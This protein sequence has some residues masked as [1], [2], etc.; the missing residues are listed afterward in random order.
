MHIPDGSL[1]PQT[2]LA[3]FA[4]AAPTIAV[5]SRR[6]TT[7]VKTRNVPMLAM[8]AAVSFLVMM[9]NIP[10]PDGTS[11]H[12]VGAVIIAIALGPWA[13]VIAVSVALLFQAL[14]FG[15][16]GLLAYG[17]NVLNLA[18][19]M[20][21]SGLAVYRLLA[22]RSPLTSRRR[23][24]AAG[25]GGF[26]GINVAA[27]ATA[28]ELGI[29]PLLHQSANGSPLYAP[30]SIIQAVAAMAFA[31]LLVAG[32]VEAVLTGSVFAYLARA[33]PA[34]LAATHRGLGTVAVPATGRWASPR[35]VAVMFVLALAV[36][37]P[38]GLL[39]Q[40]TAFGE[41]APQDMD[42]AG[43]GIQAIPEGM[44]RYTGFW[45]HTLLGDYAFADG[46]NPALAYLI[47]AGLGIIVVGGLVYL[48]G[49][50]VARLI[51][52]TPAPAL[53]TGSGEATG[54]STDA[55]AVSPA[56]E[57][58]ASAQGSGAR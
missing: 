33:N 31:H 43:L 12:A 30:Y 57:V 42:L 4:I 44:A 13:A 58:P 10:V 2:C 56:D 11:A 20:P 22:G 18:I 26:V 27:L 28:L 3:A 39:A 8:F 24:L 1:S 15:D 16:G 45:R 54:S 7:V 49:L 48:A 19:L 6:V 9:F 47:S 23:I 36:L 35:R 41:E 51:G 50:V 38:L 29:Q 5:A 55:P 37:S 17:A 52:T 34:A 46:T 32:P 14:L 25:A 40:G 53:A 21:F